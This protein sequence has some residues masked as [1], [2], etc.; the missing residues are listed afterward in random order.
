MVCVQRKQEQL[1]NAMSTEL[2]MLLLNRV[3]DILVWHL[4]TVRH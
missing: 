2:T 4:L 3:T 1:D